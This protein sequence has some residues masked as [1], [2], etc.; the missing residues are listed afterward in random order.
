[1][2]YI[3]SCRQAGLRLFSVR[4]NFIQGDTLKP[5]LCR[6]N[7]RE[8]RGETRG[9]Q[10]VQTHRYLTYK[11]Y[12]VLTKLYRKEDS[13]QETNNEKQETRNNLSIQNLK[14]IIQNNYDSISSFPNPNGNKLAAVSRIKTFPSIPERISR[15]GCFVR[16]SY[17]TSACLHIPQGETGLSL[18]P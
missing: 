7:H 13:Q 3:L 9:A 6:R 2:N 11:S 10:R 4:G 16:S 1:M 12:Y 15:I 17:S 8:H 14:F 18:V 5:K